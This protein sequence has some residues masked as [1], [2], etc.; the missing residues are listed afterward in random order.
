MA[1]HRQ[2]FSRIALLAALVFVPVAALAQAQPD[3][4]I[5]DIAG[6]GTLR[7]GL[8]VVA[9]H[10]A[11][12]DAATGELRGLSV[13]VA[14]G[15]ASRM[16]VTFSAVEYPSV[17][18]VLEGLKTSAWD[19]GFASVDPARNAIVEF[20]TPFQELDVTYFV[21]TGSTIHAVGDAD[22][23]D[24][25]IATVRNSAESNILRAAVKQAQI[26]PVDSIND[27]YETMKSGKADVFALA[28]PT[29]MA[30]AEKLPG[31]R[32][33]ADR[34]GAIQSAP[35]VPK[36]KLEHLAYINEYIDEI[37]KAGVIQKAIESD[38]VRG[39][40]ALP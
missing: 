3:P 20:A 15:L 37:K 16:H 23:P 9:P 25:R 36:G 19:I 33:L 13:E 7:V 12:K 24:I 22:K 2:S 4:R 1:R 11:V 39:V 18:A 31:S 34:I 21:P 5:A 28:R 6:A 32:V 29:L 26:L 30:L 38:H 8:A 14:R 17:P 27:A 10:F 35:V 40:S